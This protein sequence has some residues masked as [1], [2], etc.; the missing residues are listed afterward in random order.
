MLPLFY[1]Y[2]GAARNNHEGLVD[3]F[4]L[5]HKGDLFLPM[6]PLPSWAPDWNTHLFPSEMGFWT[7]RLA[8]A[9]SFDASRD[10]R[11]ARA[12]VSDHILSIAGCKC[13]IVKWTEEENLPVW[14]TPSGWRCIGKQ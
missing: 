13:D 5:L 1:A 9:A 3:I 14:R 2:L 4:N 10:R 11:Q 12:F 7:T 8:N 6:S